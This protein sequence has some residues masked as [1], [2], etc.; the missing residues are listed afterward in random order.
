MKN[1][2]LIL[3]KTTDKLSGGIIGAQEK[4]RL[5]W[6]TL[7]MTYEDWDSRVRIPKTRKDFLDIE[8]SLKDCRVWKNLSKKKVSW[9]N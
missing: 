2:V 1:K 8:K 7:P 9:K 3:K 4:N 6:E 5:W